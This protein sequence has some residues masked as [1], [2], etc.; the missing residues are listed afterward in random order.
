MVPSDQILFKSKRILTTHG[1]GARICLTS[2]RIAVAS[3]RGVSPAHSVPY[4]FR[5]Y[6]QN[7]ARSENNYLNTPTGNP[8]TW[9]VARALVAAPRYF[10]P[11]EI[12][13]REFSGSA[14]E[15]RNPSLPVFHEVMRMVAKR[16]D[17]Y[18]L[19][20]SIGSGSFSGP[21]LDIKGPSP[22]I[23]FTEDTMR[24]NVK[25]RGKSYTYHRL[26]PGNRLN[27]IKYDE[28]KK[29]KGVLGNAT[30]DQILQETEMY[31]ADPSVREA[32]R[33]I[34]MSLVQKRRARSE[35]KNNERYNTLRDV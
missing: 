25:Q 14:K 22:K 8:P 34:A 31:L 30:I 10:S 11:I 1:I 17:T 2:H 18:T 21:K 28:W 3:L 9:Q 24:S 15:L 27:N 26:N 5:S 12:G 35:R 4:L 19:F 13:N 16:P 20:I 6:D 29:T 32:L 7:L 23:G 33:A